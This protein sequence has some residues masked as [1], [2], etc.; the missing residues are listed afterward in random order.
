MIE[1][2]LARANNTHAEMPLFERAGL[3]TAENSPVARNLAGPSGMEAL[4]LHTQ[5]IAHTIGANE[6]GIP[7]NQEPL[8]SQS[9]LQDAKREPNSVYNRLAN[10]L[11]SGSLNEDA[12]TAIRQGGDPAQ[13]RMSAGSPVAQA[14]IEDL[15]QQLLN[16]TR[17][18]TGQ[19]FINEMR[20]LRQEGFTNLA[21]E[22]VSNQQIGRAQLQFARAIED[23]VKSSIPAGSDV[24]PEQFEDARKTL[25]KNATIQSALRGN[26]IDLSV[27]ARAYRAEPQLLDGGTRL[28]ADF[29]D[30]HPEVAS[31][32]TQATRYNPPSMARD[33][34]D[35]SLKDPA[36]WVRTALGK[37]ARRSMTGDPDAAQAA[38]NQMFPARMPG[39]F[40]PPP[41]APA[42]KFGGY[43]PSPDMVN[44]GGGAT[45]PG[46]LES[47]GLTPDVQAAGAQHPARARLQALREQLAQVPERP[48]EPVDFQGPQKWGD[49]SIAPQNGAPP[50]TAGGVP[51][52]NVLEQGGTQRAPVG[53]PGV[54]YRPPSISPNQNRMRTPPGA[55]E[56]APM[57][58]PQPS[59]AQMNFRNQQAAARLRKVAGDLSLEGPG[60]NTGDPIERLRAALARRG[61]GFAGGGEV[62]SSSPASPGLG[63][64]VRDALAAVKDYFVDR[65][66]R[67]LQAEREGYENQVINADGPEGKTVPD[68][69]GEYAGG[70]RVELME[71]IGQYLDKLAEERAAR[72]AAIGDRAPKLPLIQSPDE[73]ALAAAP[74]PAAAP[75]PQGP[76]LPPSPAQN[77]LQPGFL[78]RRQTMAEGGTPDD[79]QSSIRRLAD[80]ARQIN[81]SAG[82][83]A[84][85]DRARVATNL[86]SLAYG[87]DAQGNPALGGRAWTRGQGGTPAGILDALSAVPHGLAQAGATISGIPHRLLQAAQ[88][89]NASSPLQVV[90]PK[91]LEAVDRYLPGEGAQKFWASIDP[92]SS[93]E[94]AQ[95]LGQLKQRLQ[96]AAGVAPP[97]SLEDVGLD[98]VTDPALVAPLGVAR[99]AGEAPMLRRALNWGAG[100]SGQPAGGN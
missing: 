33:L 92:Q 35:I 20:G 71:R 42:P 50:A 58:L 98:A 11:P 90:D 16:P 45:T 46:T 80:Y 85:E 41:P 39:S 4:R 100:A 14:Q 12:Q 34:Q 67:E 19:N 81:P 40:S 15:K 2:G 75:V 79:T 38:A 25:A 32:P 18:F 21:S 52:E 44:A 74:P 97:K 68:T 30:T 3:R 89:A 82:S 65:P 23:H 99:V 57:G 51:F 29:Y 69:T 54:A 60:G 31:L 10:S 13:G 47:L 22:D 87:L 77:P 27:L 49:F 36:S 96:Q 48:A 6:A 83:Q 7:A 43:L 93:R 66:R 8:L 24:T 9:I 28:L 63:G 53:A 64:A 55:P 86:A 76:A 72:A 91:T 88:A 37:L 95:R 62:S 5:N 59:D 78:T 56:T 73:P 1:E 61:R 17:V 94:A 84:A 70:G 26:D